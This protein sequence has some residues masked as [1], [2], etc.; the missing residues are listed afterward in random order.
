M[1]KYLI[2]ELHSL[3]TSGRLKLADFIPNRKLADLQE[4][5]GR[6]LGFPEDFLID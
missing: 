2:W 4:N 3:E 1:K 5:L 6:F